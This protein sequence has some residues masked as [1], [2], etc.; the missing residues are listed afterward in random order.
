MDGP[1]KSVNDAK[2]K[3]V[4]KV[5]YKVLGI[6]VFSIT[7]VID[8]NELYEKM[9]LRFKKEFEASIKNLSS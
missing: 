1:V 4:F 2:S 8:E 9:A 6:P 5:V 7:H 3:P